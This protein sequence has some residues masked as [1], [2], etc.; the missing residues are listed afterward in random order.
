MLRQWRR[1]RR[2]AGIENIQPHDLRPTY[3]S[4]AAMD[5][6]PARVASRPLGHF[7]V[8]MMLRCAH[9]GDRDIKAAAERFGEANGAISEM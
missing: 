6:V 3:A 2:E 7:N 1:V 9:L 8:R 4:H 5:G